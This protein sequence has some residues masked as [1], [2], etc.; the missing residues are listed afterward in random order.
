MKQRK[1][2][3]TFWYEDCVLTADCVV[4]IVR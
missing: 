3:I 4:R 2:S 1:R